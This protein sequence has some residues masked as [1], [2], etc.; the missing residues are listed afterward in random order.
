MKIKILYRK[1]LKMS[2][3]KIAAQSVHAALLLYKIDDRTEF[4]ASVVVLGVSDKK[5]EE[6]KVGK[7]IALIRDKGLTEVAPDTETCF[8]FLEA[9]P[10]GR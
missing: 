3:G 2:D 1:N 8:A 6:Q 10:D 9:Y 5:F 7:N 4:D